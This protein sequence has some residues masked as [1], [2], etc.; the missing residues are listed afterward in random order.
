MLY[1]L[2]GDLRAFPSLGV[3][4]FRWTMTPHYFSPQRFDSNDNLG[5]EVVTS[6]PNTAV[7]SPTTTTSGMIRRSTTSLD[8]PTVPQKSRG[9]FRKSSKHTSTK[10]SPK[11]TGR[12]TVARTPTD[13]SRH[14]PISPRS[15]NDVINIVAGESS[16]DYEI[17]HGFLLLLLILPRTN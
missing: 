12:W 15:S 6:S 3:S 11:R 9:V 13:T 14:S 16:D 7:E 8:E 1:N 4:L 5:D 17:Y 10:Q 2:E